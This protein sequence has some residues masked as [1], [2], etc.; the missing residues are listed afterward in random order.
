MTDRWERVGRLFEQALAVPADAR[1]SVIAAAAEPDDVKDEV[2][3][4]LGSHDS[5]D[6]FLDALPTIDADPDAEA[7]AL[8]PEQPLLAD[9]TLVG[10]Y[11]IERVL[12]RGGMGVVYQAEDTRLHRRVALKSLIP[13]LSTEERQRERLK[14]EARAAA[15]LAHPGI[16]TIYALEEIDDQLYI[17]SEYLE[18][19]TLRTEMNAARLAPDTLV[20]TALAIARALAAAHERGIVHR[21]LKP[22]N[23]IRT[24]GGVLKILDFGLAQ[25]EESARH[26][27][28]HTKLTE[29]GLVA[30]TPA[31]MAPEQLLSR[32]TDFRV[33]QFAFGVLLY[34]MSTGIHPFD[35]PSLSSTIAQ[36]L[37]AEPPPPEST[38]GLP[39]EIWTIV[40]RCL[41]KTPA[42]R[43]PSTQDI[44]TLLETAAANL[45]P[46][47]AATITPMGSAAAALRTPDFALPTPD[48]AL[49]T[50]DYALRTNAIFWWRFHQL[51]A[52]I[53]YWTMV[54]PAWHVRGD[55][56]RGGLVFFFTLLA[57]IVVASNLRLHLWFSSRVYPEALPEQRTDVAAWIR[58]ADIVFAAAL[59][60]AG[61]V[62][63][64]ARAG[65]AAL[66]ISFGIGAALAFLIIEPASARAAFPSGD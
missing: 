10:Q 35:A 6:G 29:T 22:E 33:D 54:W 65:W 20:A 18:G 64:E 25:F 42:E 66:L 24:T 27:V 19:E 60:V 46:R 8:L 31:Y 40:A 61:I 13:E 50:P 43:F 38:S 55:L 63:P 9:G 23:I 53:A 4:L 3:S 48:S 11:R 36:I 30:G 7:S 62:L 17:A 47:I 57:A 44:V 14:Q 59:I 37:A 1:E 58:A 41:Q 56:G 26:L 5:A 16:A 51:A 28:S 39:P 45:P 2:R 12:G 49:R 34:E 52:A 32:Q 15:A 21:D